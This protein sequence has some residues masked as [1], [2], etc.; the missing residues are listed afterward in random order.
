MLRKEMTKVE[1]EKELFTQGDYVQIDNITRFLKENIPT[2]VKRF[3]YSKLV[4]I[5]EKRAMFGDAAII[6]EKLVE[7]AILNSDKVNHLT[8]AA[9]CYV[10]AGFFDK[11]DL[12]VKKAIS[13]ATIAEKAKI[14]NSIKDFYKNQAQTYENEKRR[15]NAVRTYEKMITMSYSDA[16]KNEINKKLAGLYKNLGMVEK[17]ILIQKKI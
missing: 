15:N 8:K 11:A 5:Y 12:A 2:D 7:I 4:A 16:E 3:V 6:Y 14:N 10:K 9:E 1:I 17:Y 13:E